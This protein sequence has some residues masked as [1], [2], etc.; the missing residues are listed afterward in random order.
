MIGSW[1]LDSVP[2]WAWAVGGGVLLAATYQLWAP[3]AVLVPRPVKI[4]AG[5]LLAVIL[6]YLDGRNRGAEGAVERAKA[7]DAENAARITDAASRARAD[8]DARNVGDRLRDDDG[9][10]RD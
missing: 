6:A 1:I 10:R 4:A 7:K 3:L 2:W 5:A 8:A 9:W